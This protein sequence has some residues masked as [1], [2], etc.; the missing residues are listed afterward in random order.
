MTDIS[1]AD[2]RFGDKITFDYIHPIFGTQDDQHHYIIV[3]TTPPS[4]Q[5]SDLIDFVGV[6]HG[7]YKKG[8]INIHRIEK[9]DP[10]KRFT[11][12]TPNSDYEYERRRWEI[13][14][15]EA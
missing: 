12:G 15:G 11:M 7:F 6:D 3:A 13:H 14:R 4:D 8:M 10:N 2:V 1:S 9:G 5:E